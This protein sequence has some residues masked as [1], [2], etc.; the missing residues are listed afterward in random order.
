MELTELRQQ[1]DSIDDQLVQL[2]C[3]RM[4]VAAQIADCKKRSGTPIYVPAR[5]RE[6]LQDVAQKAGA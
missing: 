1:I 3:Q 6:K 2:F 5:E 4:E